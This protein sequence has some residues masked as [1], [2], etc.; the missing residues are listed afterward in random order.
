MRRHEEFI[1]TSLTSVVEVA[2]SASRSIPISIASN[3]ICDYIF[4]S[5][6]LRMT[7]FQEQKMKCLCWEM[8][9]DDFN[10]RRYYLQNNSSYGEMSTYESKKG[11]YQELVKLIKMHD[12]KFDIRAC[13]DTTNIVNETKTFLLKVF[14]NSSLG[15]WNTRDLNNFSVVYD[16]EVK[17]CYLATDDNQLLSGVLFNIYDKS[18]DHRNRCAHNVLSYQQ[19]LP[20]L[21]QLADKDYRFENYYIR[22]AILLLIDKV[23]ISLFDTYERL[24]VR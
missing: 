4:Q 9:T 20:T 12:S 15:S 10:F 23:F 1:R 2:A 13:V 5:I 7:G 16:K 14:E 6:F 19:N 17:P 22:F 21:R 8:A 24:M 11:V 18:Y 3:P